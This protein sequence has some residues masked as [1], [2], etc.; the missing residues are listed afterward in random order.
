MNEDV[1][2]WPLPYAGDGWLDPSDDE[3]GTADFGSNYL[4]DV[5]VRLQVRVVDGV[6]ADARCHVEDQDSEGLEPSIALAIANHLRG[7]T[8]RVATDFARA[9]PPPPRAASSREEAVRTGEFGPTSHPADLMWSTSFAEDAARAA[10]HDW[11]SKAPGRDALLPP[12][13][14][15]SQPTLVTRILRRIPFLRGL[16]L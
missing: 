2:R 10:L 1:S 6:I 5:R 9:A 8:P 3:V 12:M 14:V 4:W 7:R 16:G 11:A 13:P 15:A